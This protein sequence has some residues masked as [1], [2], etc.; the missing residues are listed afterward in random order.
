MANEFKEVDP[1]DFMAFSR[2][3]PSYVKIENQ[4]IAIGGGG[5]R[6]IQYKTDVIKSAGWRYGDLTSYGRNPELAAEV[7]NH[8]RQVLDRTN[9][10]DELLSEVK[11]P[12][13]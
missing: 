1:Q 3:T 11:K 13:V 12:A 4:V 6:G 8:V 9:D 5:P 10:A 2:E 7:F